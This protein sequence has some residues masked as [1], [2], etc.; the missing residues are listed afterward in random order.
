MLGVATI[1]EVLGRPHA[2]ALLDLRED[3]RRLGLAAA[4]IIL[5]PL[6]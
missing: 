3:G 1:D 5:D 4:Y 6:S 2:G